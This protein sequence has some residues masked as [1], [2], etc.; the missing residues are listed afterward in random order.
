MKVHIL[1]TCRNEELFAYTTL[2]FNT[3]RIGF[4]T[5]DVKVWVNQGMLWDK[6][7]SIC[8]EHDLEFENVDTTHD[9]WIWD[10]CQEEKEPFWI[11]DTD[12]IFF[13]SVEGFKSDTGIAGWRIPEWRDEFTKCITR[14]RIHTSL[15]LIDPITLIQEVDIFNRKTNTID[16]IN[17]TADLFA[18]LCVPLNGENYFYDVCAMLYQAIGGTP[19]PDFIKDN[20]FHFNFG[21][22]SDLVLPHIADADGMEKARKQILDNPEL[23]RSGWRLQEKYYEARQVSK[24]GKSVV[25]TISQ[26]DIELAKKWNIELCCGN[27]DAMVFCDLWHFYCHAIDD[28][29]DTME[30]GKP[31]M[32]KEQIISIFFKAALLYNCT[33]FTTN[34]NMLFPIVLQITNSYQDS[35][36]WERSAHD[37]L[38][39]MADVLRTVGG[40]M[41]FMVAL[42]CGGEGHMRKMSQLIRERD[43]LSQHDKFGNPI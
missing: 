38:R 36:A 39:A 43:W 26:T 15:M 34:R 7:Q 16:F 10:L 4:P 29:V 22:I 37:H 19:F 12:I 41:Y 6:V 18:P 24:P 27:P 20:Y 17:P 11:C 5:A 3:L 25:E 35:V 42:L 30:D 32:S 8:K 2:V 1:T 31:V 28:L 21:T 13:D 23:G 40:E 14:S 33:F 9:E